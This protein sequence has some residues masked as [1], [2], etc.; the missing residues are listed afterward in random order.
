MGGMRRGVG[1]EGERGSIHRQ[2]EG[3]ES[4]LLHRERTGDQRRTH[5]GAAE[6]ARSRSYTQQIVHAS[7][8]TM[9]VICAGWQQM[10]RAKCGPRFF[11]VGLLFQGRRVC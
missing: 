1:R 5:A 9:R 11:R 7:K 10:D 6:H 8:S 4:T 3:S 2:H